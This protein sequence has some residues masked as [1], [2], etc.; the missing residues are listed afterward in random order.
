MAVMAI[1]LFRRLKV[2]WPNLKV[3][4]R[5]ERMH[6]E[7]GQSLVSFLVCVRRAITSLRRSSCMAA[8]CSCSLVC[9]RDL[10]L[11]SRLLTERSSEHLLKQ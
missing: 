6:Q 7:W 3:L 2:Q 4:K 5:R 10:V 1:Q 8:R 11:M 9:V